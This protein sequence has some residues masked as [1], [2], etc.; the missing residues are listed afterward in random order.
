MSTPT[1]LGLPPELRNRILELVVVDPLLIQACRPSPRAILRPSKEGFMPQQPAITQV[2]H[3]TRDE[4]L[5]VFYGRNVF[6]IP[7][8]RYSDPP[9]PKA[10]SRCFG[11]SAAEK[12]TNHVIF[13]VA[14]GDAKWVDLEVEMI[15]AGEVECPGGRH[16]SVFENGVLEVTQFGSRCAGEWDCERY[17]VRALREAFVVARDLENRVPVLAMN[18]RNRIMETTDRGVVHVEAEA[19]LSERRNAQCGIDMSAER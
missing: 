5:P 11:N 2:N 19:V 18:Q 12:N 6:W 10:W 1:L 9:G 15:R 4:A 14:V 17:L 7:H 3:Q 13:A 16:R 8:S